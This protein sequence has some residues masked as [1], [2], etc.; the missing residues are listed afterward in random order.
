MS[1]IPY[2]FSAI[3]KE[4]LT[5]EFLMDIGMMK[6][7]RW[8]FDRISFNKTSIPLKR[9]SKH[10]EL[11]PMEFMFGRSACAKQTGLSLKKVQ[12]SINQ[13][14]FLGYV[15]KR[16]SK[17]SSTFSVYTL[18]SEAFGKT[19]GQHVDQHKGQH[20]GQHVGHNQDK[21]K[22]RSKD[23][24]HP[25]VSSNP[26][27]LNLTDDLFLFDSEERQEQT[28]DEQT[29]FLEEIESLANEMSIDEVIKAKLQQH[30]VKEVKSKSKQ[31]KE[32][33]IY[34]HVFMSQAT[35]DACIAIKGS[36][37]NVETAVE[38]V[39]RSPGRKREIY[40]WPNVMLTWKIKPN[41]VTRHEENEKIA[42]NICKLHSCHS[43][44]PCSITS[45]LEKDVKYFS[46]QPAT[47]EGHLHIALSDP[48]FKP[49][50]CKALQDRKMQLGLLQNY[51]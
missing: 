11:E 27:V 14:I 12:I 42:K 34:P 44:F 16:V 5:D 4:L 21:K 22:L 29:S 36:R 40:D 49:K 25:K 3:P 28:F 50:V 8:M 2:I 48:E 38:F 37:E 19:Q 31:E 45:S 30:Q 35:L 46:I 47:S 24:H 13:L 32:I 41:L 18:V 9:Q 20:K 15:E 51:S 6:F 1:K 26:K 7:I 33:E 43:T 39:M 17:S 10:L 23:N